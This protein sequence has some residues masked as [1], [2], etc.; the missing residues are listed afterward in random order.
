MKCPFVYVSG[1]NCDGY[2]SE[3]E[4]IKSNLVVSLTED[5]KIT[6]IEL[7]KI[8]YHVHLFC[9]KKGNHAGYARQHPEKMKIWFSDLPKEIQK[10]L[11]L[12]FLTKNC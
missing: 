1:K 8:R 2:I 9:S 4:I 6:G 5:N 12:P 11:N 3:I 10:Q 7:T